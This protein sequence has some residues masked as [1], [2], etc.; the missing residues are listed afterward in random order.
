[1]SEDIFQYVDN[2]QD[3]V[4]ASRQRMANNPALTL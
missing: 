3:T 4:L 2:S 1:M